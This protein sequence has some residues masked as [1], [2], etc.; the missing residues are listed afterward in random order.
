MSVPDPVLRINLR[1][2]NKLYFIP[3][4]DVLYCRANGNY[5]CFFLTNNTELISSKSLAK[6]R[7]ELIP[8]GFIPI[9]KSYLVNSMHIRY[10]SFNEKCTVMLI[11]NVELEISRRSK[12]QIQEM[13]RSGRL[14]VNHKY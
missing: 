10:I 11:N 5:T 4:K 7:K 2:G 3:L 12:M 8:Q 13:L 14:T 1:S 6:I 9:H